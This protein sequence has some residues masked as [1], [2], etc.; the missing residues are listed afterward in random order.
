MTGAKA[1]T[2]FEKV[3][4]YIKAHPGSTN[5]QI[6]EGLGCSLTNVKTNTLRLFREDRIVRVDREPIPGVA[7]PGFLLYAKGGEPKA[8]EIAA[9]APEDT[10][11]PAAEGIAV[12]T[13]ADKIVAFVKA[14]PGVTNG[15]IAEGIGYP[16]ASVSGTSASLWRSG[17]L[18]RVAGSSSIRKDGTRFGRPIPKHY[19]PGTAPEGA[20]LMPRIAPKRRLSQALQAIAEFDA[21]A[22]AEEKEEAEAE[23]VAE[24]AQD[25]AAEQ[26]QA[27]IAPPRI[28]LDA[29]I[30][31]AATLLAD[32]IVGLALEAIEARLVEHMPAPTVI[33]TPEFSA[34]HSTKPPARAEKPH[35]L[36]VGLLPQQQSIVQS[37]Y[38]NTLKLSFAKDSNP[39][40]LQGKAEYVDRI[41]IVADFVSHAM[42]GSIAKHKGKTVLVR[43]GMSALRDALGKTV[44]AVAA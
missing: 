16:P 42:T 3:E 12:M 7:T 13:W 23:E 35:V 9:E 36:V 10:P 21:E 28:D 39:K 34:L 40:A 19:I 24:V 26:V 33:K 17:T 30:Q 29:A 37:E 31:R 18:D 5:M 38:H 8:E 11:E 15:Q 41:L 32:R 44:L 27:P 1:T 4:D 22:E 14:N 6:Q 25:I 20:E 2:W 43:G